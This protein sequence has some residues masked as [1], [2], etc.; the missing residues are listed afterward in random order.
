MLLP[1]ASGRVGEP[2]EVPD[3]DADGSHEWQPDEFVPVL[4]IR[5][6]TTDLPALL[7]QAIDNPQI[8]MTAVCGGSLILAV[9]GLIE[10]R[11][12]TTHH[13]GLDM[14]DATGVH[15]AFTLLR[16]VV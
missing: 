8:T 14:L 6:L 2:G 3:T 5:T 15:A 12:A 9:A 1:G 11:H 7:T 4:L 10:G 13:L 16:S